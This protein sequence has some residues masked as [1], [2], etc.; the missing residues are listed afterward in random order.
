MR[1]GNYEYYDLDINAVISIPDYENR[2]YAFIES[3]KKNNNAID[4]NMNTNDILT[5]NDN[6]NSDV[7]NVNNAIS[8]DTILSPQPIVQKEV[9]ASPI[10]PAL[11]LSSSII[12]IAASSLAT[13]AQTTLVSSSVLTS[14]IVDH[15]KDVDSP[16]IRGKANNLID[17][18]ASELDAILANADEEIHKNQN[19]K[20]RKKRNKMRRSIISMDY[21]EDL[22]I[23]DDDDNDDKKLLWKSNE[24]NS[25]IPTEVT[26]VT[27]CYELSSSE[28]KGDVENAVIHNDE[29][30]HEIVIPTDEN[31]DEDI[32]KVL[33]VQVQDYIEQSVISHSN[34][35]DHT[36]DDDSNKK[37]DDNND[38]IDP[39][40][41]F[42]EENFD[43]NTIADDNSKKM[44][45][46]TTMNEDNID[47]SNTEDNTDLIIPTIN[48]TDLNT[49]ENTNLIINT[50]NNA[51]VVITIDN[52]DTNY[53]DN[54]D[55]DTIKTKND[56]IPIIDP[57]TYIEIDSG[58]INT[59][60]SNPQITIK[61]VEY[62]EVMNNEYDTIENKAFMRLSIRFEQA[63]WKY[64][65]ELVSYYAAL[66]A[67]NKYYK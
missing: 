59:D 33:E 15:K 16:D 54:V 32:K 40:D 27:D 49:V 42:V 4:K 48:D 25:I 66:Q 43:M 36:D 18:L 56:P 11:E 7:D 65:W 8:S 55:I 50:V 63:R 46:K 47:V 26:T 67:R 30:T 45:D 17:N 2:Y 14:I 37:L 64:Q 3:K 58:N 19:T 31:D 28:L 21:L 51:D 53:G 34:N 1:N 23:V 60:T 20:D 41:V 62:N 57:E 44:N 10:S 35:D 29:F 12:S 52:S 13:I 24:S 38:I 9:T 22:S 5:S 6:I 39:N 61:A